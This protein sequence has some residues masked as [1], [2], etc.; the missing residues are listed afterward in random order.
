MHALEM[1]LDISLDGQEPHEQLGAICKMNLLLHGAR[2]I[3]IEPGD[4]LRSPMLTPKGGLIRY[5]RVLMAPPIS[6]PNWGAEDAAKDQLGRF[7]VLPPKHKADYAYI[8][9][10]LSVLED[11]GRAVVLIDRGGPVSSGWRGADQENA[12]ARRSFRGGHRPT[13]RHALRHAYS[14]DAARASKR[15]EPSQRE[16]AFRRGPSLQRATFKARSP[17]L[18]GDRC[19]H[20]VRATLRGVGRRLQGRR[21]SRDRST[22]MDSQPRGLY[23]APGLS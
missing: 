12:R 20:L 6:R 1:R 13:W 17:P 23:S 11:G 4:V 8:L 9:H 2:D 5:D 19:H 10:C 16:G 7:P 14:S 3:R 22:P 18:R 21:P 15:E